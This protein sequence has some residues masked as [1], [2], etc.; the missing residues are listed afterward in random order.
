MLTLSHQASD[1]NLKVVETFADIYQNKPLPS[2]AEDDGQL[3]FLDVSGAR[4]TE[5]IRQACAEAG[6]F[7]W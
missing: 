6:L 5:F 4:Y 2:S 3:V 1:A 7:I